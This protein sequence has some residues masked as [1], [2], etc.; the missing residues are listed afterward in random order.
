M[1][2]REFART[3]YETTF[4]QICA[5][6]LGARLEDVEVV[7][8]APALSIGFGTGASRV[9]VNTGNAVFKSAEAVK[10]KMRKL[11]G[12]MIECDPF[13]IELKDSKAFV[14]GAPGTAISFAELGLAATQ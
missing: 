8:G 3:E 1:R 4:A 13:D 2:G 11:A 7:G 12:A 5:E 9:L 10:D 6:H 14:T